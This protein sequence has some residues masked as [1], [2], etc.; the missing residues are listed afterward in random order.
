MDYFIQSK[1]V[2]MAVLFHDPLNMLKR[3]K[4]KTFARDHVIKK[5]NV[6]TV[7]RLNSYVK[8]HMLHP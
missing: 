8:L 2:D 6:N 3:L 4:L 1:Q 7:Y 5:D